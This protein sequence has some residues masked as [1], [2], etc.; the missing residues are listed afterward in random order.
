MVATSR[1]LGALLMLVILLVS[2]VPMGVATA[3]AFDNGGGGY[4]SK[5]VSFNVKTTLVEYA[6]YRIEVNDTTWRL[7]N[8]LG[9][10][11]VEGDVPDFWDRVKSDGSDI[12]VFDQDMSQLYFYIEEW[13]YT[14]Q[15]AVIWVR[16]EPGVKQLNFA[17]GNPNAEPSSYNDPFKVFEHFDDA[18]SIRYAPEGAWCWIH[19]PRAVHANGKTFFGAVADNGDIVIYSYEHTTKKLEKF[20]LH[21]GLEFDDH[22]YPAILILPNGSLMAVYSKHS[23]GV[24]RYRISTNPYDISSW[25]PEITIDVPDPVTYPTPVY[26]PAENRIYIF[27]RTGTYRHQWALVYSDD[28]GQTWHGPI[29]FYEKPGVTSSAHQYFKIITNGYDKIFFALSGHP[30]LEYSSIYFMYYKNG[31]FYR[32][33]GTPIA[34]LT[35]GLPITRDRMDVVYDWTTTGRYAWVWDIAIDED[36]NP[37]IA[38]AAFTSTSSHYYYYA[39]WN[40][41][42][43]EVYE[44]TFAGGSIEESGQDPYYSGGI[45]I[46]K[47]EPNIIYFSKQDPETGQFEIYKGI[48]NDGGKTWTFIQL[49]KYSAYEN[50]RPVAVVNGTDIQ[51]IWVYGAYNAYWDYDTVFRND[52][53]GFFNS[54]WEAMYGTYDVVFDST[55][56]SYVIHLVIDG[57]WGA[58][59]RSVL[60]SA[61]MFRDAVFDFYGRVDVDGGTVALAFAV[62]DEDNYYLAGFD[63]T[64]D[65]VTVQKLSGGT[66][67]ALA[68]QSFTDDGNW[69]RFTIIRKGDTIKVLVDGQEMVSVTDSTFAGGKFGLRAWKAANQMWDNIKVLRAADPADFWSPSVESFFKVKKTVQLQDVLYIEYVDV[70]GTLVTL[71]PPM[72]LTISN[73]PEM[74]ISASISILNASQTNITVKLHSKIEL[75][76]VSLNGTEVNATLIGNETIDAAVFNVYN[77][78]I[79]GNGTLTVLGT[80]PNVLYGVQVPKAI[81]IGD[82]LRVSLPRK[83][84]VSITAPVVEE[85]T[86]SGTLWGGENFTVVNNT[87]EMNRA[88]YAY[89]DF[90]DV[91]EWTTGGQG[92]TPTVDSSVGVPPPSYKLPDGSSTQAVAAGTYMLPSHGEY[93]FEIWVM[94]D[95][96]SSSGGAVVYL[97]TPGTHDRRVAVYF[98]ANGDLQYA[99][100]P[101]GSE[102]FTTFATDVIQPGKWYRLVISFSEA[103]DRA[104]IY[105]YNDQGNLVASATNLDVSDAS[106]YV[107]DGD[108]LLYT[109]T[110]FTGSAYFDEL[111]IYERKIVINATPGFEAYLYD[112]N[113]NLITSISDTD[114]DGLE[115]FIVPK[116]YPLSATLKIRVTTS[117]EEVLFNNTDNV[118]YR[119]ESFATHVFEAVVEDYIN[120]EFGYIYAEVGVM[121]GGFM[122]SARDALGLALEY[123]PI[124]I[125][126][127]NAMGIEIARATV[128][129]YSIGSLPAGTYRIKIMFKDIV[130]AERVFN[131]TSA[132]TG[133]L[134]EV[135]ANIL[136]LPKD[137]RGLERSIIAPKEIM[138]IN[139]TSISNKYPYSR[140]RILL[141]GTGNFKLYVN[142]RGDVPTK[143]EVDG[144]ISSLNYYW[145][146]NYLVITGIL[147]SIGEINIT[148]LYKLRL[149]LYDRLGNRLPL[150]PVILINGTSYTGSIVEDYLYPENYVIEIP[151]VIGGFDFYSYFDGYNQTV[152][153]VTINHTDVT[154]KIWY[155]VPTS[156]AKVE[157]VQITSLSWLPFLKQDGETVKVYVE[158]YLLDYYGHG[159]PNRPV[160]I[161]ITDAEAG[162]TWMVNATTD[163]TGYFRT[164]LLEL[165]RGRTYRID[166]Y[167][168]GDD[169]YVGTS[170][171]MEVKPE[172]L[173]SALAP[174]EIPMEY[175]IIG[176]AAV[177][178]LIGIAAAAIKAVRQTIEDLRTKSRRFV[179]KK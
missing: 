173:P 93:V 24:I 123:E 65:I 154:L 109:T 2:L 8:A 135:I 176:A 63:A 15:Y 58:S 10:L 145:D 162:F 1:R 52:W 163:A 101:E 115:S 103:N 67:T 77:V 39:R 147:G 156:L 51:V 36:E 152:R 86:W 153:T 164:P 37:I 68:S 146:G 62:Q 71:A 96:T 80:L 50:I 4:W 47:E 97:C 127:E 126:I 44:V 178:I 59:E 134:L 60:L 35:S 175:I 40:G 141:N 76:S 92:G 132:T 150:K 124:V 161:N 119:V 28:M 88:V 117:S 11:E 82:K 85:Y 116:L 26:L 20:V 129:N 55:R 75:K 16:V 107:F 170:S 144:N 160:V 53:D 140:M 171:T 41:T 48:T 133:S 87:L 120:L 165:V 12:R 111:K 64:N 168:A 149:E 79:P 56:N 27:Y 25:G 42:A 81:V 138:V 104:S 34:N 122:V 136:K 155:R 13:N 89:E 95:P 9:E 102:T 151:A 158:G 19:D 114:N 73:M 43:W 3:E 174:V 91:S 31:T 66:V 38:F 57:S 139:Y 6:Q 17:Y 5:Y 157:G 159:V 142:Y 32:I 137:Y 69:H 30:E 29:V 172:E 118:E 113:G 121:Y 143:V 100:Y 33:D 99:T 54:T 18:D 167:Y 148:D 70:S 130:V 78:T 110:A 21:A 84:N 94:I 131:L 72:N 61:M 125:V 98:L 49:T 83:A 23:D 177:L 14:I 179:R 74:E 166:V 22:D 169:I 112:A 90:S 7:Y 108:V 45:S 106:A 46:D 105:V 128:Y